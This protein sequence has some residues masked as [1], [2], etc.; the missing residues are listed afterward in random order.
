MLDQVMSK[1]IGGEMQSPH[2]LSGGTRLEVS[3]AAIGSGKT[4]SICRV[5]RAPDHK[6]VAIFKG[7]LRRV[8]WDLAGAGATVT[9]ERD[10]LND[11]IGYIWTLVPARDVKPAGKQAVQPGLFG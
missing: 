10:G 9:I 8:G 2:I 5:N 3:P 6:E 11:W 7:S 4:L 1:L